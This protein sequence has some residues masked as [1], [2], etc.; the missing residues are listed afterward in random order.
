VG[1]D[2]DKETLT[3]FFA[4]MTPEERSG[5]KA[6]ALEASPKG[7]DIDVDES[8]QGLSLRIDFD[9]SSMTSGEHGTRTKHTTKESLKK[10]VITLISRVTN[11]VF[12]FCRDF[13]LEAIYGLLYGLLPMSQG[14]EALLE[15]TRVPLPEKFKLPRTVQI[16]LAR[17]SA[18]SFR[19]RLI[20]RHHLS[21][22]QQ[23]LQISR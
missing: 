16:C 5:I 15:F 23:M 10:E 12:Q 21:T 14:I 6:V 20:P 8:L 9:M 11:D 17:V 18:E 7:S 19:F 4:A 22:N 3:P 2:R 13:D 1:K